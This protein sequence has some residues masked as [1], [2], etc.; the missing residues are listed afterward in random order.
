MTDVR[1]CY[2]CAARRS[3]ST[4]F[5]LLLGG[6][7][8]VA[9]LGEFSFL[10]KSVA[11]KQTCACGDLV[12]DCSAWTP[13]FDRIREERG[14]D[15]RETPYA[16]RQWDTRAGQVI[17]E[18]QQT[19]AYRLA[20]SLRNQ[21]LGLRSALPRAIAPPLPALLRTG[22]ANTFYLYDVIRETWGRQLVV[23]SSKNPYKALALHETRPEQVRLILLIRD[24]R[25]VYHSR[26]KSGVPPKQSLNSWLQYNQRADALLKRHIP[27][28][29]RMVVHYE[30]LATDPG[31]V[32][33]RV[34][35]FLGL[36]FEATMVDLSAGVRH[37]VNGNQ[38]ATFLRGGGIRLDEEWRQAMNAS[39]L[40][41]FNR[42]AGAL[43]VALGY[44][45]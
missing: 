32:L 11:L 10:G 38:N 9:S 41:Y 45:P 22:V 16:L 33:A 21:W 44:E 13:V 15:L 37:I 7:S 27:P 5:D 4:F 26:R 36:A 20:A 24:G 14:I 25:G 23:D 17:D 1:Y 35:D 8:Q 18:Q 19:R 6:H 30:E 3:G 39:E 42:K 43:N 2:I 29:H 12:T 40:D 28:E 31:A 34:C